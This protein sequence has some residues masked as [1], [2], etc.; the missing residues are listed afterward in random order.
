MK[1]HP[2]FPELDPWEDRL[3]IEKGFQNG[4]FSAGDGVL[5]GNVVN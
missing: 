5:N 2:P 1:G 3:E 4:Q